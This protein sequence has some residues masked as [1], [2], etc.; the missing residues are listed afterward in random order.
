MRREE[1]LKQN[2]ESLKGKTVVISGSTGGLGSEL[3]TLLAKLNADLVLLDRNKELSNKNKKR[4]EW[5][6]KNIT[7]K[8]ISANLADINSVEKAVSELKKIKIDYLVHNAAAYN[9][10]RCVLDTGLDNVFQINFV[11]PYFITKALISQLNKQKTRVIVVGSIA[12]RYSKTDPSDIDFK[13]R[14][15]AELVY[16]N[17][18]RY[19]MYAF[20]RLFKNQSGATLSV[21]H[22]GI[23]FTNIT[24]H[25]PKLLFA[26]IKYPMKIIFMKPKKAALCLLKGFFCETKANT[27]I[28]PKILDIWGY[29]SITAIN[30]ANIAESEQIFTNAEQIY[31]KILSIL[32]YVLK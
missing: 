23:S 9:I 1:W 29:P 28:G 22:P 21:V 12:H 11:A 2:T 5:I 10:E 19:L 13:T 32:M 20:Y 30:S 17:S 26:V 14:K 27:W 3:C 4:L 18:K 16:G 8:C 15:K 7:V 24:A 6:N 25:Y 31:C